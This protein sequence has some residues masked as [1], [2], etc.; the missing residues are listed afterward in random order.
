MNVLHIAEIFCYS[1]PCLNGG[2]CADLADN[3]DC[4]CP[5]NF[6]GTQCET[7]WDKSDLDIII[8]FS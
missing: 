1:D 2:A 3:F 4:D 7:G 8:L 5:D 6:V